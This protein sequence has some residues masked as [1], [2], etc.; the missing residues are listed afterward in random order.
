[1]NA[2]KESKQE[3]AIE[4]G[5]SFALQGIQCRQSLLDSLDTFYESHNTGSWI[6]ISLLAVLPGLDKAGFASCSLLQGSGGGVGIG[7][8]LGHN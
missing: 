4:G 2:L 1:M 6:Q 3:P 7:S 8:G 5:H